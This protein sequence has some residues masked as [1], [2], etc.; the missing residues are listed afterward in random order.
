MSKKVVRVM[1]IQFQAGQAK[2]G[3]ALAGAGI[4]MPKF[5]TAFNDQTKDRMGETVPVV[6]TVYEDKDFSFEL[7]TAP[8]SEKIKKALGI[9]K[10]SSNAGTTTVG[11]LSADQLKEIAEYKMPDLNANDLDA[12]MKI[13][14]GTAKN[15]G[16]KVEGFDA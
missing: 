1:K 4:Q 3:P 5:C 10:G 15:M 16:V 12:A 11:T 9:K 7:K 14:A 13:V 2:P 6:L 8:A